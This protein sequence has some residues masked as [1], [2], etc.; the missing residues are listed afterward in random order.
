METFDDRP[1]RYDS[2]TADR[3]KKD[4]LSRST[5]YRKIDDG[6]FPRQIKINLRCAVWRSSAMLLSV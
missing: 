3:L 4:R 6:T 2:Q 1:D 5:L